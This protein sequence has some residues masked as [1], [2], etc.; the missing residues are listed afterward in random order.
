[1]K[2]AQKNI[3]KMAMN[4]APEIDTSTQESIVGYCLKRALMVMHSDFRR[5]IEE[6]GFHQKEIT[7]LGLI[8]DNPDINQSG[9]ARA[10]SVERP[11]IVLIV[12]ELETA[13]LINRN[14]VPNDRRAYA[15]RI[16]LKGKQALKRGLKAIRRHE[17]KVL[18]G[19]SGNERETLMK[20]LGKIVDYPQGAE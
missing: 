18:A 20:L 6:I 7:A 15:L 14:K 11:A 12:D 1:M 13:E 5:N 8:A 3:K 16:T 2:T 4:E 19:L 9:L 17:D 10:M